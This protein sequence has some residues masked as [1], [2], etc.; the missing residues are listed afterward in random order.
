MW[1]KLKKNETIPADVL[2]LK[3]SSS[4]G[5]CFMQTSNLD[6]E[7]T[8]KPRD[9]LTIF[10]KL[11]KYSDDKIN[12]TDLKCLI[13][14]DQPNNDIHKIN[15]SISLGLNSEVNAFFTVE[16]ILLRGATL[17]NTDFTYGIV[18]YS[19]RETK[20]MKNI[21][22]SSLKSSSIEKTLIKWL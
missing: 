21:Q 13:E 7:S 5:F 18:I 16:N 3:A 19:G 1:S 2:V 8:L 10:S 9:T 22:H 6:G 11:I 4:N 12:L 20:I 17:K 14:V 15:G